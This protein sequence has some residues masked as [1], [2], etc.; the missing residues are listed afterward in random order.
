ELFGDVKPDVVVCEPVQGSYLS[1]EH[2][3]V[4]GFNDGNSPSFARVDLS[5]FDSE[6]H[7]DQRPT[8]ARQ[9]HL[10]QR[11]LKQYENLMLWMPERQGTEEIL[12]SQFSEILI[13]QNA[14]TSITADVLLKERGVAE[15]SP[16]ESAEKHFVENLRG[17]Q[18]GDDDLRRFERYGQSVASGARG[19]TVLAARSHSRLSVYD[20]I[21]TDSVLKKWL[22][23]WMARHTF[24]VSQLDGIVGC[25]FRFFADRMLNLDE[26]DESDG[27]LP[28]H[29]FGS[30]A[31]DVLARFY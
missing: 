8:R 26:I 2:C 10:L 30:F 27:L 21:L 23:D 6:Q 18:L 24:S 20:G 28:A 19:L 29:V 14:V 16:R 7:Q 1:G 5:F 13:E 17:L 31:H 12:P 25:S 22:S 11:L 3:I 4:L 9:W 15:E